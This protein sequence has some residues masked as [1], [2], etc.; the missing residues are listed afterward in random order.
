MVLFL[1]NDF[2]MKTATQINSDILKMTALIQ[3]EFP[4][5]IKYLNEMPETIP[6]SKYPEISVFILQ[7][8]YLSLENLLIK[9]A[10]NHSILLNKT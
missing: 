1:S 10:P 2:E 8:Y 3:K 4:E 6:N 7:D 5:L 9:Y